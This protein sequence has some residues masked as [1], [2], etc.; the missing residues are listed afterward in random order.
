MQTGVV[1]FFNE[2]RGFG[3]IVSDE[4]GPD[5]YVGWKNCRQNYIPTQGDIVQFEVREFPDGRMAKFVE[6]AE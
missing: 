1:K 2:E 5:L 3:F 6:L 4:P